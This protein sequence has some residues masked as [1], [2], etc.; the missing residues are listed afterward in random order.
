MPTA[1]VSQRFAPC[2]Q[3][4]RV[5]YETQLPTVVADPLPNKF[6]YPTIQP[7]LRIDPARIVPAPLSACSQPHCTIALLDAA[8]PVLC[9]VR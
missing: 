6:G 9:E 2:M 4:K 5:K 8:I 3:G 1:P 7:M